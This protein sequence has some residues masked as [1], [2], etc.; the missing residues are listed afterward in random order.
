M[1]TKTDKVASTAGAVRFFNFV[2]RGKVEQGDAPEEL[3]NI[4]LLDESLA[5]SGRFLEMEE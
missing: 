3:G 5:Q 1:L 2:G 4:L